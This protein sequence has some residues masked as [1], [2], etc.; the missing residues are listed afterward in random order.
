MEKKKLLALGAMHLGGLIVVAT[1]LAGVL[2]AL[3]RANLVYAGF[4]WY[5]AALLVVGL[6][7]AG[8]GAFYFFKKSH[9]KKI[10]HG[11]ARDGNRETRTG[12]R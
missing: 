3:Y 11:K 5:K 1:L 12:N 4:G 7:I 2:P 9:K 10:L 6:A 8:F